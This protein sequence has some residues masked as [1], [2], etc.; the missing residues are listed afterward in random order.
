MDVLVVVSSTVVVGMVDG[1]VS[2]VANAT[3][4]AVTDAISVAARSGRRTFIAVLRLIA[5]A[6]SLVALHPSD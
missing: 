1:V 6:V 3:V 4:G 5:E 2:S